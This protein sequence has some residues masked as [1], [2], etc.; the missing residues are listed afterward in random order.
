MPKTRTWPFS[1]V[2]DDPANPKLYNVQDLAGHCIFKSWVERRI[3][4]QAWEAM[5]IA[6][7]EAREL[8]TRS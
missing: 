8:R 3:A 1:I 2:A 5:C 7:D 6:F 4:E